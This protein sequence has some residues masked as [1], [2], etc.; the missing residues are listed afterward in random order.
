MYRTGTG[1]KKDYPT[2]I[3]WYRMA[4]DQGDSQSQVD[5]GTLFYYGSGIDKDLTAAR[6]YLELAASNE[7]YDAKELLEKMNA[8]MVIG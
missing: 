1:V 2:A 8:N 5:L 6:F 4:A 7:E 3:K